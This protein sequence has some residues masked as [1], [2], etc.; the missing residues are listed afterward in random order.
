MLNYLGTLTLK[1]CGTSG[2]DNSL[3]N[4][5]VCRI[6]ILIIT[7]LKILLGRTFLFIRKLDSWLRLESSSWFNFGSLY[8]KYPETQSSVDKESIV[9][10]FIYCQLFFIIKKQINNV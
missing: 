3:L 6:S 4:N 5:P 1:T 10:V 8:G 7:F 2:L 9:D